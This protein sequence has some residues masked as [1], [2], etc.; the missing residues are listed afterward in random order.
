M[1]IRKG[2][3][4]WVETGFNNAINQRVN[5]RGWERRGGYEREKRGKR[6]ERRGEERRWTGDKKWWLTRDG[7]LSQAD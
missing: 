6:K 1:C 5:E 3:T 4:R 2:A 7:L